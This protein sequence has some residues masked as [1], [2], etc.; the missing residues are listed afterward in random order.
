M[1]NTKTICDL[2][3]EQNNLFRNKTLLNYKAKNKLISFSNQDLHEKSL[4]FACGLKA[5]GV[6]KN[7]NL[8]NFSYQNPIWLIIDFGAILA[9]LVTVPIFHNISSKNLVFQINDSRTR[10][11]FTDDLKLIN[12][13]EINQSNIKIIYLDN[14]DRAKHKFKKENIISLEEIMA[15]GKD[16]IKDKETDF[17]KLSQQVKSDDLATIIYTSGSTGNPKGVELTHKNLMSQIG[18]TKIFFPLAKNDVALS[19]LPLAH[20][21]ERMVMMYYISQGISIYFVD[22][23]KKISDYLQEFKPTLMTTVPRLLEKIY[24]N[25][26][27]KIDSAGL[28]KKLIAKFA[29][30]KALTKDTSIKKTMIDNICD[31]IIYSKIRQSLGGSLKMIICGGA[32]ISRDMEKFFT[33]IGL[34]LYPGYGMTETSP[35]ISANCPKNYK[36]ASVGKLYCDVNAR[37]NQDGE[38]EV[39]G[40][41]VMKRYHNQQGLTNEVIDKDGWLKTGDLAE[42]DN[43]GFIKITGR[44]KELFKTAYGKYVAPIP[45]EQKLVENISFLTGSLVIAEGKQFTS[46]LLFPDFE[47][48]P[49]VKDK[50]KF[51]GTALELLESSTLVNLV[52]N[53]VNQ[54]NKNLNKWEKIQK[55][56]IIKDEISVENGDI[57][58]SMKLKRAALE[59]KYNNIIKDIY[60]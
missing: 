20:I 49:K 50:M 45:I 57:T 7:D 23:V 39:K 56:I 30:K 13:K 47:M 51:N 58:P 12:L 60:H 31:K 9:G 25:I 37:I 16:A 5:L 22:D 53:K 1:N 33:N 35:V 26:N 34:N 27:I 2:L 11:I 6:K 41:N 54:I 10:I 44:K 4:Q 8:A 42:I 55:F 15:A 46:A 38:L 28:L 32:M 59:K 29:I 36:F 21:F 14:N 19:Y 40:P 17:Q 24:I 3:H 18:S 43:D 52:Q 48:L